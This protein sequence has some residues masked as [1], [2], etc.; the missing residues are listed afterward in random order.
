MS[1][2]G[3]GRG[4]LSVLLAGAGVI[5]ALAAGLIG[6]LLTGAVDWDWTKDVRLLVG[7]FAG[8]A[9][10]TVV[11]AVCVTV[12]AAPREAS[13][14]TFDVFVG[15]EKYFAPLLAEGRVFHHRV[16]LVGRAVE[17]A[18]LETALG[19]SGSRVV[20]LSGPG[21][22]GK[23][24]LLLE[25]LRALAVKTPGA[26]QVVLAGVQALGP[27]SFDTLSGGPVVVVVE[28]AQ[29]DLSA[30]A[31]ILGYARRTASVQVLVTCRPSSAAAV[32]ETA[33][34]AYFDTTEVQIVDLAPLD[35]P[36][37]R[38]LVRLLAAAEGLTLQ[39]GFAEALASEGRDCPLVPV[40]AVSMV[41]YG[42]LTTAA[43]A[44]NRDFRRE[45]LDRFGDVMRAGVPGIT[46]DAAG[47]I[48]AV[49]AALSPVSL[50]DHA[51]LDA[52][53]AFLDVSKEVILTRVEALTDHGVLLERERTVRV[54]PDVLGDES[55]SRAAVRAGSATGYVE[56][57]WMAF[58]ALAAP[59]LARNLA[60]LDWR[61]QSTGAG[62]D[63]LGTVWADIERDVLA[64]DARGRLDI[65]PVLRDLAGPQPA[66][67]VNLVRDL[68]T[69][70]ST[71]S[72]V[73]G[74]Y[75]L[76]DTAVRRDLA[77]ILG[78]CARTGAAC[79]GTALDLL[80]ELAC[81]DQRRPNQYPEHA[82]RVLEDLADLGAGGHHDLQIAVIDAAKRWLD[83]QPGAADTVTPLRVLEPLVAKVGVRERWDP[84]GDAIHLTPYLVRPQAVA[85]IRAR[86]RA[87]AVEYGSE[88][89]LRRAV[90]AVHLLDMALD[91]PHGY[92]GQTIS[93]EAVQQWRDEDADTFEALVAIADATKEPLVRL[94][95]RSAVSWLARHGGHDPL[96]RPA[97][98]LI[99]AIDAHTE[100]L[101]T[102]TLLGSFHDMVPRG[103]SYLTGDAEPADEDFATATD[104]HDHERRQAAETLWM[105]S[106]GPAELIA[107]LDERV[108]ALRTAGRSGTGELPVLRAVTQAR[109]EQVNHLLDALGNT[110]EGPLDYHAHVLL[111]EL[112]QQ[113]ETRFTTRLAQL[114]DQR[115]ALAIGAVWGYFYHDWLTRNPSTSGYLGQ[116]LGH[117]SVAV[118]EATARVAGLLL[119]RATDQNAEKLLPHAKSNGSWVIS[120]LNHAAH[121]DY[122]TW[123][124][125]LDSRAR[126]SV[127]T[128]LDAA[129]HLN[130]PEI[131]ELLTA[132]RD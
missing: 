119:D 16:A 33:I 86:V 52:V 32:R 21:G 121:N 50:E 94:Q 59:T 131:H 82:L 67:V 65:L 8:V 81:T 11:V 70:S 80:W 1:G 76:T 51:L 111:E 89:E 64:A 12:L 109:P 19:G 24:R 28:D 58:G 123:A 96:T 15:T 110:D 72:H 75:T 83:E 35:L 126:K 10:L 85:D 20:V 26:R 22:R 108:R 45:I 87:L 4:W 39:D 29:R 2:G 107:R 49:L 7:L 125:R 46:T 69:N 91:H 113:D 5:L 120:A 101:L 43:L 103:A 128:L 6:N 78:I 104:R 92:F 18:A 34:S 31:A 118:R 13:G 40:V 130:D 27:E 17:L 77:P 30:L 54:V 61:I 71:D 90:D 116:A 23:S 74:D 88:G 68:M 129:G 9:V 73:F 127:L 60:E 3:R 14:E 114:L 98:A 62:P 95:V 132:L 37:A 66:R 100:D 99:A 41:A 124:A 93:D 84:D 97:R 106:D 79:R 36:A 38:E 56:R 105:T 44:L 122:P 115:D 53:S 55:L 25:A 57:L 63:L 42:T 112:S 47:E 102:D 48:L 117:G